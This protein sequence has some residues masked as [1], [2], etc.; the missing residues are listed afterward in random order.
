ML[1]LVMYNVNE[2]NPLIMYT[3]YIYGDTSSDNILHY[4]EGGDHYVV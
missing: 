1:K 4:T 2:K 3:L